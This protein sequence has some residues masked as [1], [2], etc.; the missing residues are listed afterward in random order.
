MLTARGVSTVGLTAGA[1]A[2][3]LLFVPSVGRAVGSSEIVVPATSCVD[4]YIKI[5]SSLIEK[6][7]AYKSG[8]NIYFGWSSMI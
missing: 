1:K 5:I 2:Y 6:G 4:E 3:G 7:F 8:E